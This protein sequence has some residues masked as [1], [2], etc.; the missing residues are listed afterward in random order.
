MGLILTGNH[1]KAV[2]MLEEARKN[3]FNLDRWTTTLLLGC[4]A[5]YSNNF[6]REKEIFKNILQDEKDTGKLASAYTWGGL[7]FVAYHDQDI[8]QAIRNLKYAQ[9]FNPYHSG[10]HHKIIEWEKQITETS[11]PSNSLCVL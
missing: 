3:C 11:F 8:Q 4:N 10:I 5:L 9:N 7:A 2:S 6:D 1:G